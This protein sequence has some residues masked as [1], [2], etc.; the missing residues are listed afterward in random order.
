[1][2]QSAHRRWHV[3]VFVFWR[4]S[5]NKATGGLHWCAKRQGFLFW[6]NYFNK[7]LPTIDLS[8]YTYHE[9]GPILQALGKKSLQFENYCRSNPS[10]KVNKKVLAFLEV[11]LTKNQKMYPLFSS[12]YCLDCKSYRAKMLLEDRDLFPT[13]SYLINLL[14][15]MHG[16]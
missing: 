2:Q 4:R 7:D 6:R 5:Y 14:I 16:K 12:D 8:Y 15:R 3:T 10:T 9:V 11:F 13:Y 1:M